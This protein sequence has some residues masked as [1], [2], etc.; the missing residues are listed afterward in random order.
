MLLRFLPFLALDYQHE[1]RPPIAA[2]TALGLKPGEAEVH[3]CLLL[4]TA[5]AWLLG[6]RWRTDATD[7][8]RQVLVWG[9]E[10]IVPGASL[11]ITVPLLLALGFWGPAPD[12]AED[13][14]ILG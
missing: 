5:A 11:E 10:N 9:F 4:H 12:G 2:A 6:G 14:Q 1:L 3:P 13:R 8:G 7:S